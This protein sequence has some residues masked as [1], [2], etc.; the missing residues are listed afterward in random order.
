VKKS[1]KR[2]ADNILEEYKSDIKQKLDTLNLEGDGSE[3]IWKALKNN[4]KEVVDKSIPRK[5]KNNRPTQISQGHE[6]WRSGDK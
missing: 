6:S 2:D 1:W 4:F 5:E 3:K